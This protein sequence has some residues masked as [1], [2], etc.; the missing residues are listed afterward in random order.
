MLFSETSTVT[1]IFFSFI[2][3]ITTVSSITEKKNKQKSMATFLANE[4]NSTGEDTT[5]R[6]AHVQIMF[7]LRIKNS[8]YLKTFFL[9]RR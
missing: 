9:R 7:P 3:S 4:I 2:I 5:G 8:G 6:K 1:Y